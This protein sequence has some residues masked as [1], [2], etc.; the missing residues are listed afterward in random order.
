[1]TK[2]KVADWMTTEPIT[3]N[4]DA[5]VIEALHVMKNRGV[6]RLPVMHDGTLAGIVTDRILKDYA[7][8]KATSL[9]TWEVHYLLSKTLVREVMNAHPHAITPSADITEAAAIIR[10]NK[11]YGLCVVNERGDLI[12]ILTIKDLLDALFHL[13]EV[14]DG[15]P[16]TA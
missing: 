10:D 1:M 9:D 15:V 5:S 7:P 12:G 2:R 8:G 6:R 13:A 14:A 4:D 16:V 11:L 3:I